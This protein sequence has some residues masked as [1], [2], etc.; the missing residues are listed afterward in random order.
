[1]ARLRPLLSVAGVAF[2]SLQK[3]FRAGDREL[4]RDHPAIV[5]LG[6]AIEDFSDTA[7]IVSLLDLVV[8]SDTSIAHLAGALGKPVWI[9]LQC[10]ADWRWLADRDDCPW[11]PTARLFRQPAMDDW[12]SVLQQVQA[13]LAH[14]VGVE[15]A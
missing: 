4:L 13:A 12:E 1:L 15:R 11:Y 3:D 5:D 9:L 8:S 14:L 6:D 10:A 7:A 2:L